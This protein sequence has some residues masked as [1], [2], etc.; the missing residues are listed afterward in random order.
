MTKKKSTFHYLIQYMRIFNDRLQLTY[1]VSARN[2]IF[3]MNCSNGEI[4]RTMNNLIGTEFPLK[5][6]NIITLIIIFL[7]IHFE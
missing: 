6:I 5:L 2:C 3:K 1:S 4:Q 7:L